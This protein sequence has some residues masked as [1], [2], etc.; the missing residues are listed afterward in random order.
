MM[1][2]ILTRTCEYFESFVAGI[3]GV[4]L[5]KERCTGVDPAGQCRAAQTKSRGGGRG[6]Q[7][8]WPHIETKCTDMKGNQKNMN[9]YLV[10]VRPI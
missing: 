6:P 10:L 7:S 1:T 4:G 9:R 5:Q 3:C 2:V 8:T